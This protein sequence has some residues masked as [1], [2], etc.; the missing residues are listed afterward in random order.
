[1]EYWTGWALA[2]YQWATGRS[3]S[4]INQFVRIGDIRA[5]YHPYH[6]M[7]IR[8]FCD[9]LDAIASNQQPATNLQTKRLS[10]GLSQAK[11]AQAAGVP[12]RT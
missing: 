7:D 11:L 9:H 5:L 10:A 8:Q 4:N 6:E 3:F 1:M 2:Y 12:V